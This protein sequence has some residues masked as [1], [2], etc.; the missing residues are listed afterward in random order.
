VA[1]FLASDVTAPVALVLEGEPGMGKTT[2]WLAGLEQAQKRGF[3]V[4]SARG[5]AA[6]SALSHSALADLLGGVDPAAWADLPDPQRLAI[7][8]ILL[9][10][11]AGGAA[12][13]PRA[14]S[15]A[16]LSLV[17]RLAVEAPVLIALDDLQ[18]L[19]TS[20]ATALGFAIRRLTCRVVVLATT[21]SDRDSMRTSSWLHLPTPDAIRRI[22]LQPLTVSELHAVITT[23]LGRSLPRP[24][25]MKIHEVSGGNPFFGLE[26][27]RSLEG[28]GRATSAL[29]AS[30]AEVVHA[31][32]GGLHHDV[33][34]AL[35][36][37]ACCADPTVELV[38]NA[39]DVGAAELLERLA[40]AETTGIVEIDG[41]RLR[42][43]HPLLAHGVYG[44]APP[45]HR[46]A[47]HKRLA[48]LVQEPESRARHLALA[49]TGAT[50]TIL[51]SL[52]V[53][54]ELA[55]KRGAPAAAAELLDLGL[56]LGGDTPARQIRAASHH[57]RAGNP[58][59]ARTLLNNAIAQLDSG[60]FRASALMLL[61]VVELFDDS[62]LEG[63]TVL[64]RGLREV[65]EDSA[66]KARML[67]M[68][69]FALLNVGRAADALDV[70]EDAVLAATRS[71]APSLSSQALGMRAMAR[72]VQGNGFDRSD[73]QRAIDMMESDSNVP[74]AFR[75]TVQ[76]A[77]LLAWSGELAP[78]RDALADIRRGCAERGAEGELVFVAFHA[79]FVAIWLGE[80]GEA[81]Q[82][83]EETVE[84][85]EQ[86]GG[87]V[88][89]FVALTMRAAVR[90][91][92]GVEADARSD[93]AEATAASV[94][95]GFLAMADWPVTVLGFLEVSLGNYEAALTTLS[96]LMDRVAAQPAAT[97]INAGAFIPDAVEALLQLDRLDDAELLIDVLERNGGRLDR[98]WMSA[99]GARCRAMLLSARGDVDEANRAVQR[100][101][102]E[103]ERIAMPF[104]RARTQLVLGR[105]QRRGGREQAATASFKEAWR[106]FEQLGT[107]LWAARAQAESNRNTTAPGRR[108]LTPS[109]DKVARLTASGMTNGEVAAALFISPKTVEF[110]LARIYRK[111][112]IRSRAELGRRMRE[113]ND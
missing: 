96:P 113:P 59:N 94:R 21:R 30:L 84:R 77:L 26:L 90:S 71:A 67:V 88:S 2:L 69:S 6:E 87:N 104:E 111:L 62:F 83:A 40:E 17:R 44:D 98:P 65:G 106:I 108:G 32:V 33:R 80:L 23:R 24:T 29:P 12:T 63:V 45:A 57:L 86:L 50:P 97:E 19:D 105:I 13:D 14:V 72:F 37:M 38:A 28:R 95:S 16:L 64:E 49:A 92:A 91:H 54:A 22:T 4:L 25:M 31:R 99:V 9:L 39:V 7:E 35:L 27:A 42:F 89:S 85:A 68:L 56:E 53:A 51:E 10:A 100:A 20:S 93:L 55:R 78:A 76:H 46:R 41:R 3:Q 73:V 101:L 79:C 81:N 107:P 82:L 74:I 66:L 110:H 36:A 103:H 70:V 109:E 5:A 60:L 34:Q 75:P 8:H 61:A 1:Q 58:G 18:W 15:A 48:A 11:D 43:T 112:G 47:M 102:R 52:D